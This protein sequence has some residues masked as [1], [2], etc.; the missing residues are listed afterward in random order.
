VLA[1]LLPSV[2]AVR[3]REPVD[4]VDC[5]IDTAS[6]RI[7]WSFF[8]SAC[9]P[10]GLVSLAPDTSPRGIWGGG[11]LYTGE[12]IHGFSH[13][14]MWML[15]GVPVLP[16]TGRMRGP[17]GS[18]AYGSHYSHESETIH[19]GYHAVTLDDYGVRAEITSTTRVGMHR[20]TFPAAEEAHILFD[21]GA[22]LGPGK[23]ATALCRKAS[24]TEIEGYCV[25]APTRRRPKTAH[26]YFVA[27]FSRPFESFGGWRG[28][29]VLAD[30]GE[31]AGP[32][33]GAYVR[34]APTAK[35][36]RVLLKVGLSFCSTAQARKNLDAELPGWDFDGVVADSRR[37]WNDWL[38]RIEVEGGT[39]AQRVKFYTDLWHTLLG[40]HLS[41]D[42]DG[43]YCDTTG[44]KP[45]VRQVPLDEHG[46][47][48]YHHFNSDGYWTTFWNLNPLW[49]LVY[50]QHMQ[51]WV[52]FLVDMY[53]DGGLIPRGPSAHNY[54]FVMIAAH[55]TPLI[56]SAY[57]KGLRTFDVE[58]AYEGLRKNHFPGGLMSKAGYEHH[59][60]RGGGVEEYIELGYIPEDRRH[61]AGFHC[62]SAAQTLEYAYDDWC[63]AQMAKALGKEDDYR[64]FLSRAGNYRNLF[65]AETQFM[66]PRMRDGSWLVPFDPLGPKGFCE[67]NAWQYTFFAPHD[68]AGLIELFGSREAFNAKLNRAFELSAEK[69]FAAR[70]GKGSQVN[71]SNQPALHMA[72]LFNYSGAPWLA[73]KWVREV[74]QRAFGGT[75]P[76][77]G[78]RSDD[79]QGQLGA[80]GVL[81]AIGLFEVRGGAALRPVYEITSPIFD[82]VT[83]HLDPRHY[84]GKTFT[85]VAQDN[86]TQNPYIQSA[87]LDGKPLNRPWLDHRQVVNGGTLVLN[88]G[89]K[90]NQQWG[91]RPEDAPPSMSSEAEAAAA[92]VH[93]LPIH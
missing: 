7:R 46:Q 4:W 36:E 18:A 9:R 86:S 63:L 39:D 84:P 92:E 6:K 41:S 51:Q 28:K 44:P 71:Y 76:D 64:L 61:R 35:G 89:P 91:S 70:H 16:T 55:S 17:E 78:Y 79:D 14:H 12:R 62:D 45:V 58:A 13:L 32:G 31:V 83:I 88:L 40:R 49:S 3:G 74:K 73:Q 25:N 5:T 43:R 72:H 53:K 11:Y 30:V 69:N 93:R 42:V 1:C 68:V 34:Y 20:Y 8:A 59:T 23:M 2:R 66:R 82:R 56:V 15:A 87:T 57:M 65:D 67:G 21:L 38:G 81:M 60:G 26:V 90:P 10:F 48:K 54:T 19:P 80:L 22:P 85:I 24:D 75:T 77:E 52:N 29:K 27:R 50:P 47:P 33:T 37:E